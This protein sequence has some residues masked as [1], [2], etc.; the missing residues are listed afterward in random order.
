MNKNIL[1]FR[2][3]VRDN[4]HL[5]SG[6][7]CPLGLDIEVELVFGSLPT[8]GDAAEWLDVS[9]AYAYGVSRGWDGKELPRN[10]S[11]LMD[12]GYE[13]GKRNRAIFSR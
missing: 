7:R 9:F 1:K 10:R 2:K 3:T 13:F 4:F 5:L 8:P 11:P 12:R 6:C